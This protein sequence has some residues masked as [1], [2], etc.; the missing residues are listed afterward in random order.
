MHVFQYGVMENVN[1]LRKS[2]SHLRNSWKTSLEISS[3]N[4]LLKP[5]IGGACTSSGNVRSVNPVKY[6]YLC[7]NSYFVQRQKSHIVEQ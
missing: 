6:K 1:I 3:G 4:F 5:L 2:R 7:V